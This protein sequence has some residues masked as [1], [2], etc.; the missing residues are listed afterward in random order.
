MA[1]KQSNRPKRASEPPRKRV[2]GSTRHGKRKRSVFGNVMRALLIILLAGALTLTVGGLVF[3]ER[4]SLPDANAEFETQT[5]RLYFRDGSTELGQLAV[6]NRTVIGF[7]EMPQSIKDA[8]VA[9]EDRTF[10]TNR[11][12]DV[13]GLSRAA[14]G[15]IRN[16]E[17][18]G[19]GS[20]ITQQYIK[21]RYL[22]SEQ[23]LDRKLTE[24]A[25][26]V[27]MNHAASK[28]QVLEGYLNTIYFGRGAY[29]VQ[30]AA[31]VFFGV[32]AA[33][34]TVPQSAA[35]AAI[36][37]QPS[38]LD[39]ANGEQS[40]AA[41][42][43][44]YNYVLDGML[45][46]VGAI[47]Q[48]EYD[49][50]YDQ[51][52][53][54]PHIPADNV[55]GGP[56]GFL[57]KMATDELEVNGFTP[58]QING[59]GL[60]I[61]LTVD[62]EMQQAAIDAAESTVTQAVAAGRPDA[63]PNGL[64]VGLA[65]IEVGTGEILALYGG[66]DYVENSRNWA[67]TPR[68]AASTFKVWGAVAGLRNG[69]GLQS[70]LQG[71]SYTPPGDSVPVHNDS[72]VNY[73]VSTLLKAIID[74]SNTTFVDMVTRIPNGT[75]EV[76]RA[77]NDGGIPEHESWQAQMNRLVLGAGEVTAL[78]NATGFATL[79]NNGVLNDTHIVAEV[80]DANG[81]VI[82]SGNTEGEQTIEEE[83]TR[84]VTY[85]L[86]Q[87]VAG[88]VRNAVGGRAVAGKTGTE[89]VSVGQQG[90]T[91]T[92]TR[93]AWLVGYTK[94]LATSVVMVAGESGNDNLDVYGPGGSTFYGA[95]Y[96]T[97]VWNAYMSRAVAGMEFL[98][99]DPPANIQPTVQN[100]LAPPVTPSAEPEPT[101]EETSAEP[102]QE[103]EPTEE[104]TETE[105]PPPPTTTQQPTEQ[106]T[107]PEPS[108]SVPEV[109]ATTRRAEVPNGWPSD[110][111][112]P[113][114]GG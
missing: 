103:P 33:D 38:A 47:S 18:V 52:P 39:P 7:D 111:E 14:W 70:T 17:I 23:T 27:K 100:T 57:I 1:E 20:T 10:W 63:D 105:P 67:T 45:D 43:E 51:L 88:S 31:Q 13:K 89:G 72:G 22:T 87:A 92:V 74:S 32:D 12:I 44:R 16:Q 15:I 68:Y 49:E 81:N 48:A 6:Q 94:Q 99:F 2:A 40:Q 101:P 84:D 50:Y 5:T 83:V 82:H 56:N 36:I 91:E 19:G 41:L 54:F 79:A 114:S 96:P 93:A 76:I 4:A 59:G 90:V 69:F 8:V 30:A 109:P 95:G 53:E 78:D 3:Y 11:G 34:L 80:R 46:P 102:T 113:G 106:P 73:G 35:L 107:L 85:A 98:P 58:E 97:T 77:A 26:A 66:R 108:V 29:G 61:Y 110:W 25:L 65:S 55:Y 86:S 104:P 9:A 24:L 75:E 42:L 112:W 71:N 64:H 62:A 28:E 60:S 21:I 37:N